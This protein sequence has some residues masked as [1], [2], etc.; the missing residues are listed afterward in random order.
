MPHVALWNLTAL[1]WQGV[2]ST[3]VLKKT[4]SSMRISVFVKHNRTVRTSCG[5]CGVRLIVLMTIWLSKSSM[6]LS[7][8]L[9]SILAARLLASIWIFLTVS[10][11]SRRAR[12]V[13]VAGGCPCGVIVMFIVVCVLRLIS[14]VCVF[15][16]FVLGGRRSSRLMG[17]G[18]CRVVSILLVMMACRW[19][20]LV[21]LFVFRRVSFIMLI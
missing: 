12:R 6:R 8:S 20:C 19:V 10:V 3:L 5:R 14:G 21:L 13:S 15:V 2:S 1:S 11:G 4:V 16:R 18:A 9:W 7:I 17:R